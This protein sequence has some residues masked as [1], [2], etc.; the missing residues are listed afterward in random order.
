MGKKNLTREPGPFP[1]VCQKLQNTEAV[2][3]PIPLPMAFKTAWRVV[4]PRCS[5]DL[6]VFSG[7]T[8]NTIH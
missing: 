3:G 2:A 4:S 7:A 6:P 5:E 1:Q 8:A